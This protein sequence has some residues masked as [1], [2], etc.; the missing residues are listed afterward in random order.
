MTITKIL[1]QGIKN[2]H[3]R[4]TSYRGRIKNSKGLNLIN[5]LIKYK[6]SVLGFAFSNLIPFTNNQAERDIRHCKTKQSGWML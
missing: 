3:Q 1:R 6:E 4:R 2:R 5:R